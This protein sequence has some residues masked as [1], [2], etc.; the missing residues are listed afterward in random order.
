MVVMV[1]VCVLYILRMHWI[2]IQ[3]FLG[4]IGIGIQIF[5]Q[6]LCEEN[7]PVLRCWVCS[8]FKYNTDENENEMP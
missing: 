8:L 2:E 4:Q 3:F 1:F 7:S 5:I 6:Q